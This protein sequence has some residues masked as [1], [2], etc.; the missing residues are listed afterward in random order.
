MNNYN[1]FNVAVQQA[2]PINKTNYYRLLEKNS[3]FGSVK[4]ILE[5]C[6]KLELKPSTFAHAASIFHRVYDNLGRVDYDK[7]AIATASIFL[8][9]KVNEDPIRL[10]DLINV[11]QVTL[12]RQDTLN[13]MTNNSWILSIRDT[14]VQCEMFIMRVLNFSPF[15]QLP[16]PFLLNYINTLENWLPKEW[17]SITPLSKCAMSLLQDFYYSSSAI[18]YSAEQV[19]TAVLVLTFQI[20]GI[21]I[22]LIDDFDN[23]Y[24]LFS[25]DMKVE[26]VWEIIEEILKV[27]EVE[28]SLKDFL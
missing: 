4:F 17:L 7:F 13:E 5:C 18:R 28:E 24:K 25:P 10:K 14:I 1:N 12:N 9:S 22:P 11:S 20:Y 15:T 16:H 3:A 23:W 26:L 19:A 6:Q 21:K 2:L 8:A 27:F